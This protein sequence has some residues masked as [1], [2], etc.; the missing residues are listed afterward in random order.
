MSDAYERLKLAALD[1]IKSVRFDQDARTVFRTG[2]VRNVLDS[3][4][5]ST[6]NVL[7]LIALYYSQSFFSASVLPPPCVKSL[8]RVFRTGTFEP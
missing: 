5:S 7:E 1:C 8:L 3:V 6:M 2:R 4:M